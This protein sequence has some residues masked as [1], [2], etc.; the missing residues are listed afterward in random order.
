MIP[1]PM[2]L[3]SR[4]EDRQHEQSMKL[5][6]AS[7]ESIFKQKKHKNAIKMTMKSL[8]LRQSVMTQSLLQASSSH[9]SISH[10]HDNSC[11][12][13]STTSK[14]TSPVGKKKKKQQPA[15]SSTSDR[16]F[17]RSHNLPANDEGDNR[18][19]TSSSSTLVITKNPNNND[20]HAV[21]LI[22]KKIL[23]LF[24]SSK[25]DSFDSRDIDHFVLSCDTHILRYMDRFRPH[26][27]SRQLTCKE[28]DKTVCMLSE[29]FSWRKGNTLSSLTS[30]SFPIEFY[31][32]GGLFVYTQDKYGNKLLVFRLKMY[33]KIP[34][35][36][37]GMELFTS[38]LMY[39]AHNIS[40]SEAFQGWCLIFDLT[41]VTLAQCDLPQFFWLINTFLNYFPKTLKQAYVY[42]IAWVIRK[43]ADFLMNFLPQEYK[44]IVKFLSG[45]EIFDHFDKSQLPDF[46]GGTCQ[47]SYRAIPEGARPVEEIAYEK[48]GMS[49]EDCI[50]IQK[51]FDR[52]LPEEFRVVKTATSSKLP[53]S[54]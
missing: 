23:S 30:L 7:D 48:Y 5:S 20:C 31:S 25:K 11:Q 6:E 15:Q 22:R 1:C 28:I 34:E 50:R 51:H 33:Q 38:Y 12:D 29:T 49:K 8:V 43:I 9:D 54:S 41:D 52:F 10:N 16:V 14:V 46:M 19:K 45:D 26:D 21:D 35:L 32:I 39:E 3:V 40:V 42:N 24:A 4:E 17:S 53:V 13:H 2:T 47:Q 37:E 36:Q 18:L 44:E 27:L